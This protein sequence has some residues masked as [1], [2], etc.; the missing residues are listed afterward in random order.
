MEKKRKKKSISV[1]KVG[2]S[3]AI[4]SGLLILSS[5]RESISSVFVVKM[6][7]FLLALQM[8]VWNTLV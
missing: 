3:S 5:E 2:Y 7:D 4:H 1:N 6:S 8:V